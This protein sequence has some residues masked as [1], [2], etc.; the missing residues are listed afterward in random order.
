MEARGSLVV[1]GIAQALRHEQVRANGLR[2]HVAA[3]GEGDRLALCLHGFPESWFSWRFQLPLLARLG[4]RAWAPDLRGYGESDRPGR[5]QDYA[6]ERLIDDVAG[7]VDVSGARTTVL[8]AHDWGAVVAWYFALRNTRPLDGLV[9]LNVPHPACAERELRRLAQLRRSWYVFFFQIP[10]LPE[11]LLGL[12]GASAI[13]EAFRRSAVDKS[14]FPDAVVRVYQDAAARPGA[15]SAM[16]NYYRALLR[17]GGA[18]RQRALGYPPIQT[19]TLMLWGEEDV[20]LTKAT[21]FG[22]EQYVRELTLRY[23]PGVSHWVQQEAPESVNAM[24]EAWL[25]HKPVPEHP[26]ADRST[27]ARV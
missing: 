8:L 18:R 23:L 25:T 5:L 22:T 10:W 17:G 27:V 7:L 6:I 2:F 12:R 3:C 11:W 16:L 13:G 15:L 26:A 14:R 4:Y 1:P 20:A 21:T 9:I 19:R 24:L